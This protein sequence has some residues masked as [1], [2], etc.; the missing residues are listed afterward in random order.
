LSLEV[1][2]TDRAKA[3]L[4]QLREYIAQDNPAA[5]DAVAKGLL[6]RSKQ[7]ETAPRSGRRV[8]E[9]GR[10]DIRELLERPY[11]IIYAL[12]SDRVDVIAVMHYRQLLPRDVE[13]L[14]DSVARR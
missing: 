13:D 6:L 1:V 11:R 8:P 5:A 12:L 2:W 9:Y 7:L 10:D 4:R 14:D 3:R